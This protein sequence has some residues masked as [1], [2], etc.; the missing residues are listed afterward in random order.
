VCCANL[1]DWVGGRDR[2]EQSVLG[3]EVG[4]VGEDAAVVAFGLAGGVHTVLLGGS[5]V[6]TTASVS[7]GPS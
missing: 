4:Q 2:N 5:E 7:C 3:G 6:E 1:F